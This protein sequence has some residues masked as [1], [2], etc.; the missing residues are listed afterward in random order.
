[1]RRARGI[2][3]VSMLRLGVCCIFQRKLR[4]KCLLQ[5]WSCGAVRC[6]ILRS[7]INLS[8]VRSEPGFESRGG[9]GIVGE[10]ENLLCYNAACEARRG[11]PVQLLLLVSYIISRMSCNIVFALIGHRIH[12]LPIP[13]ELCHSR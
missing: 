4:G 11:G 3:I 8:Q 7:L 1:M 2:L 6:Y 13:L 12:S 5:G 9:I 10:T